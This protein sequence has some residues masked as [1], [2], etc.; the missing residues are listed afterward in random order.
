MKKW[1]SKQIDE[2]VNE[3]ESN[4]SRGGG[5]RQLLSVLN[6]VTGSRSVGFAPPIEAI[7]AEPIAEASEQVTPP[8]A[9]VKVEAS[10]GA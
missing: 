2:S 4:C 5:K 7:E 3:T 1:V 6:F 10:I 8:I 9:E